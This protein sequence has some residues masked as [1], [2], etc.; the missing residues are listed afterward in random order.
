MIIGK[1]PVEMR[2]SFYVRWTMLDVRCSPVNKFCNSSST[3]IFVAALSNDT[4]QERLR[5]M[6]R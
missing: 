5:V 3:T 2:D 4:Y 6:A 1:S